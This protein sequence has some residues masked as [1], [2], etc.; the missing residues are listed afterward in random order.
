MDQQDNKVPGPEPKDSPLY[1]RSVL[2]ETLAKH[3]NTNL[4]LNPA[5]NQESPPNLRVH[6]LHDP[7]DDDLELVRSGMS[8]AQPWLHPKFF[9]DARGSA[10]FDAITATPEYYPTRTEAAIFA[11][12]IDEMLA[13]VDDRNVLVEPGSGNCDKALTLLRDEKLT[14]Y[15]PIEISR[16]FLVK[17]CR[18]LA[19]SHP[20]LL[21]DAICGDFT[22]SHIL[23]DSIPDEGRLI[24]FPGSTIG[25]FDPQH[26]QALLQNFR[27]LAGPSGGHLLIGTDL[28]KDQATLEAAYNDAQ[29]LTAQFNLNMLVHLNQRLDCRFLREDF[30][31]KAFYNADLGRIEMHLVCKRDTPVRVGEDQFSL[32]AGQSIHT[33]SSYKYAPNTFLKLAQGAGFE[34]VA[35]WTDPK[36]WFAVHLMRAV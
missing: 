17:C 18:R 2:L 9:Y 29:G 1:R 27:G 6:H 10:L 30:V 32:A 28:P 33:E 16:D 34:P 13:Y 15:A 31:H 8:A 36:E 5:S 26:A 11:R 4:A 21:V 19:S 7:V 22:R 3:R 20:N 14:H 12:H 23:P 24:F 35:H 25:N